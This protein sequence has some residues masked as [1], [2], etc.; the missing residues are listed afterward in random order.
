MGRQTD[1]AS[2]LPSIVHSEAVDLPSSPSQYTVRNY[3]FAAVLRP[4][5]EKL[6]ELK[7]DLKIVTDSRLNLKNGAVASF[8]P[9]L[10]EQVIR[11]IA[12]KLFLSGT[13]SP[14]FRMELRVQ[15]SGTI[16]ITGSISFFSPSGTGSLQI[17]ES[18]DENIL[19]AMIAK[20][21]V[22]LA[23]NPDDIPPTPTNA[24]RQSEP[25]STKK[26]QPKKPD[27]KLIKNARILTDQLGFDSTILNAAAPEALSK[28]QIVHIEEGIALPRDRHNFSMDDYD[29]DPDYEPLVISG[30]SVEVEDTFAVERI[31]ASLSADYNAYIYRTFLSDGP[32]YPLRSINDAIIAKGIKDDDLLLVRGTAS[33]NHE[34]RNSD[35]RNRVKDWNKRYGAELYGAGVD[36]MWLKFG[37]LGKR[38][39]ESLIDELFKFCPEIESSRSGAWEHTSQCLEQHGFINFWWD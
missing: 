34:L 23:E 6:L 14:S 16:D 31:R 28:F 22:F 10:T 36:W 17:H 7:K 24:V 25:P 29:Y 1:F 3:G 12:P 38:R 9:G 15:D 21:K 4:F 8:D 35:V 27:V 20:L 11:A 5:Y 18:I 32:P 19:D 37:K 33:I 26:S 13:I 39:I 30:I 2:L